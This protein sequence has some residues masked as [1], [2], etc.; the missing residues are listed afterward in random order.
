MAIPRWTLTLGT[1]AVMTACAASTAPKPPRT[2]DD[3]VVTC[4]ACAFDVSTEML[5]VNGFSDGTELDEIRWGKCDSGAQGPN[6][7]GETIS[8]AKTTQTTSVNVG[9]APTDCQCA[10][11]TAHKD[12]E[13]TWAPSFETS[14]ASGGTNCATLSELDCSSPGSAPTKP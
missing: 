2:V 14:V 1:L 9:G 8:V 4:G 11:V 10:C 13:H 7:L 6:A 5:T 12:G 3:P